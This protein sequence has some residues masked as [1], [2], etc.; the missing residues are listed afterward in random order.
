MKYFILC[1]VF[2]L[3]TVSCANKTIYYDENSNEISLAEFQIRKQQNNAVWSD[4]NLTREN[5]YLIKPRVSKGKLNYEELKKELKIINPAMEEKEVIFLDYY[6]ANDLCVDNPDLLVSERRL[7]WMLKNRDEMKKTHP[8]VVFFAVYEPG[9]IS[10]GWEKR[11]VKGLYYKDRKEYL[12]NNIF[13]TPS[14]CGT[15]LIVRPNGNYFKIKGEVRKSDVL[16]LLEIEN[17]E[18]VEIDN[19]RILSN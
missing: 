10:K 1:L 14:T 18:S 12:R 9:Y 4:R 11:A 17:W 13:H 7:E 16:G 2:L 19:E 8:E 3:I 6:F 15:S 5:H